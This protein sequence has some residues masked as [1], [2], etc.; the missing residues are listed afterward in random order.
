MFELP[1]QFT[2]RYGAALAMQETNVDEVD[3]LL[4]TEIKPDDTGAAMVVCTAPMPLADFGTDWW[5]LST[6]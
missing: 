4:T 5:E 3:K 6:Q 2:A 1:P